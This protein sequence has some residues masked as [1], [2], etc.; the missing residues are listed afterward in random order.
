MTRALGAVESG[1]RR[2]QPR[3]SAAPRRERLQR[4]LARA[5]IA[6]RRRAEALIRAGRVQING[7]PA[8]ELGT[9][10]DQDRDHVLVDGRPVAAQSAVVYLAL[11]KPVGVITTH[12]DPHGRPTVMELLPPFPGL[13]FVGRLDAESEGLLLATTDGRWSQR[14]QHPRYGCEKE[15][16]VHV[17]GRLTPRTLRR[18]RRPLD[19]GDGDR[20][21]GAQ[22]TVVERPDEGTASATP[23]VHHLR[24]VL[25]EG[26]KRQIRRMCTAVGLTVQRLVRVRVGSVELGTLAPGSWRH[27]T[28]D[29]VVAAATA[30]PLVTPA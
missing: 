27:L 20:S 30:S 18:L 21:S 23:A 19:L 14:I 11:H 29:E 8:T 5:G 28:P 24:I 22:V 13:L 10:V 25:R 6:S 1:R 17:T 26:R 7:Q 15:Y 12:S 16:L 3:V 9:T 2:E 4:F